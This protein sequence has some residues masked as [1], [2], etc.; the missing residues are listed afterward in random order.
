MMMAQYT[1]QAGTGQRAGISWQAA[2]YLSDSPE[3]LGTSGM[4]GTC[5]KVIPSVVVMDSQAQH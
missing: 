4:A 3:S 5:L 1:C 2:Y